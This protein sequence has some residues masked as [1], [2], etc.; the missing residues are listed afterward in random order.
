MP[1]PPTHPAFLKDLGSALI[2]G[3]PGSGKT[4]LLLARAAQLVAQG[5]P[6]GQLALTTFAFRSLEY[7][8]AEITRTQPHLLPGLNLGTLRDFAAAQLTAAGQPFTFVSNNQ[9]RAIVRQV[10]AVQNFPGSL[11]SAEHLI[12]SAKSRA[13]KLPE[14][15]PGFPFLQAYQHALEAHGTPEAPALD[16]HDLIRQHL[17]G[18]KNGTLSTLPVKAL[19][20][21]NL[22]DATEL[23]LIWL[24]AHLNAGVELWLT[25]DDDTTAY[26]QDGALGATAL[27]QVGTWAGVT[28]HHL[29]GSHRLGPPLGPALIKLARQLRTREDK[30]EACFAPPLRVPPLE[31]ISTTT[32]P[33]AH[34]LLLQRLPELIRQFG[35]VGV[36]TRT[37]HAA[38]V[39]TQV[40]LK[41]APSL[42]DKASNPLRPASFARS[43]WEDPTPQLVLATLYLLLNQAS[44]AHLQLVLLGFG[45]PASTVQ[46]LTL[47]GLNG[48]Q[49]LAGGAVLP[50]LE[51]DT[52]PT[53][54]HAV[55]KAQQAWQAA[56]SL[57]HSRTL[58]PREI[59]KALV[60]DLLPN[61]PASEHPAALLAT[62]ALLGLSGKL[63]AVLPQLLQESLPNWASPITVAPVVEVR[64]REFGVVVLP[65]AQE[66]APEAGQSTANTIEKAE[67]DRRLLYL[68]A[69]R[70]TGPLIVLQHAATLTETTTD[71][72]PLAPMLA[73]LQTTLAKRP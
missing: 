36:L 42:D 21:D 6:P 51:A 22:Q 32:A 9:L 23:Q 39:L 2:I 30:P 5:T 28:T 53:T 62:E 27:Q 13:K 24:Q 33:T 54:R 50:P 71:T 61:L 60:A 18:L 52:S 1:T 38:Q 25:A 19:L 20:L 40:L 68:A 34:A 37:Q 70:T 46:Q 15:S 45:I 10:M 55:Q 16:R 65:Y 59:F 67:H 11:A 17:K 8:K 26:A 66:W 57:W 56:A 12:R 48:E 29:P 44:T 35:T 43:I 31:V 69:T 49:W 58:G 7:L 41:A 72:R 64:N 63:T 14:A 47:H 73:E 4:T 3:L